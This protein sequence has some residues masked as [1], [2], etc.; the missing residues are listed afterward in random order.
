MWRPTTFLDANQ[1]ALAVGRAKLDETIQ[2]A[3][4]ERFPG[5]TPMAARLSI[6]MMVTP[7]CTPYR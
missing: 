4:N 5:V 2:D 6:L 1:I 7:R 3:M